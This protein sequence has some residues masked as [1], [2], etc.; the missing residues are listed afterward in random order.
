VSI[1]DDHEGC[2]QSRAGGRV[3]VMYTWKGVVHARGKDGSAQ[4]HAWPILLSYTQPGYC[5]AEPGSQMKSNHD[6]SPFESN[7]PPCAHALT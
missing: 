4:G 5:T 1:G 6:L 7:S 2:C 3:L